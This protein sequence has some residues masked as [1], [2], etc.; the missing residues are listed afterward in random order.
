MSIKEKEL[1]CKV[2]T[3]VFDDVGGCVFLSKEYTKE[4]AKIRLP[5]VIVTS[6]E[7]KTLKRFIEE[8]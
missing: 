1:T 7:Y 6:S 5:L 4:E 3:M 2:Y 8:I